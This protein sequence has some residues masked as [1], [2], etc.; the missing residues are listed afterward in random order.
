MMDYARHDGYVAVVEPHVPD[1]GYRDRARRFDTD[2][3]TRCSQM[4]LHLLTPSPN[5]YNYRLDI[6]STRSL[7]NSHTSE[8]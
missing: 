4:Y 1:A 5:S 8:R 3:A 7:L 6:V 2:R